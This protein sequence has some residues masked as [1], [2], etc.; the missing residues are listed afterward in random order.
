MVREQ[1][2]AIEKPTLLLNKERAI[3]NIDRMVEKAEAS[4]V[5]FRPHFKTHQSAEIGNWFRKRGIKSITVS[6]VDMADYFASYGWNDITVAFSVNLRQ[7]AAMNSLAGRV[8]LSV[9]I[10][11]TYVA[12]QLSSSLSKVVG[13]MLKIPRLDGRFTARRASPRKYR[14][15]RKPKSDL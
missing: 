4:G 12:Q 10:E 9:L 11:S 13:V 8:N 5:R 14:F 7:A 15:R 3:A 1:I 2:I 6:S